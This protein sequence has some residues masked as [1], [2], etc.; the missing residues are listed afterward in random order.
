MGPCMAMGTAAAHALCMAGDDPVHTIDMQ[1]L[2]SNLADN[3]ER[4]D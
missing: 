2:Q 1:R 4:T 3:L